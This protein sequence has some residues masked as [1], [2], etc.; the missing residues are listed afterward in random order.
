MPFPLEMSGFNP[1]IN[2]LKNLCIY[3]IVQM[4]KREKMLIVS[5]K[6]STNLMGIFFLPTTTNRAAIRY[7]TA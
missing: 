5:N 4:K 7:P 2:L 3:K 6:K 1:S